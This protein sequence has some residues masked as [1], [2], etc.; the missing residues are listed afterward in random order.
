MVSR[1]GLWVGFSS[2]TSKTAAV[3]LKR[4]LYALFVPYGKMLVNF[5]R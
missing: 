3:E 5:Q 1:R 2:L 4:Q